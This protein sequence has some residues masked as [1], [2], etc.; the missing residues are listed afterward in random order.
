MLARG[1]VKK[2]RVREWWWHVRRCGWSTA[3]QRLVNDSP[4]SAFH[5]LLGFRHTR[6]YGRLMHGQVPMG[7]A[8]QV[9]G[10]WDAVEQVGKLSCF[11]MRSAAVAAV[12]HLVVGRP[13]QTFGLEVGTS[14]RFRK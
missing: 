4:P 7:Q 5:L 8:A 14:L 11:V 3:G 13:P 10:S 9:P 2:T 12:W 6:A 1:W